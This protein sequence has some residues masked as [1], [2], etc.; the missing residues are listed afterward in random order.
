MA[1]PGENM[2]VNADRLW[3][4]LMEMARIGPGVAGGNN[5]QT[6]TDA[7]GNRRS[8]NRRHRRASDEAEFAARTAPIAP[9]RRHTKSA[10]LPSTPR[11]ATHFC[12]SSNCFFR[13]AEMT[14]FTLFAFRCWVIASALPSRSPAT[15]NA[16]RA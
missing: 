16:S 12:F 4:S 11:P 1:A 9:R 10:R 14:F 8:N 3:D 15:V 6:L 5:R 13:E 2:R 7:D